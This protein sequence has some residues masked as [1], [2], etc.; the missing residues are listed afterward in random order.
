MRVKSL[1]LGSTVS[2]SCCSWAPLSV[3]CWALGSSELT[4]GLVFLSTVSTWLWGLGPGC[5]RRLS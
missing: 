2:S 3:S 5:S 4:A 1:S